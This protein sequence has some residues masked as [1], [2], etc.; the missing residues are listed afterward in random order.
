MRQQ[1]RR[2]VLGVDPKLVFVF[3]L[4]AAVDTEEFR[5]AGLRVLDG[6]DRRLVV[7]FAD[8][9][10]LAGFKDRLD[11]CA[12]GVPIGA[13]SEPYA[14]LIDAIDTL[15]P[16]AAS[17]RM[18]PEL[19]QV[20]SQRPPADELRLD[21][22]LWHPDDRALAATWA[23]ELRG[24]A[25]E[26]G[27]RV[28]DVYVNDQA[29][30]ILARVYIPADA[31]LA[32]A[33]LDT[34]AVIDV[35]PRPTL[36]VPQLYARDPVT[37][38]AMPAPRDGAPLVGL[39]DSGVAS[40][41]PLVGPA[42][43]ATESLSPAITDGEDRCG[44][45]TMVAGRILHGRVD[46][47]IA[48]GM[49]PRPFCRIVSVAVLD[50]KN[51]FPEAELWERDLVTAIEWCATNGATIINLSVG[52][53][54]RPMQSPRQL[55]AAALVDEVARRHDLVVVIAAGNVAPADYLDTN[56]IE[57]LTGYPAHL[58]AD[59]TTRILDPATSALGLTVG[60]LTEA[61]AA[62]GYLGRETAARVPLG[63]PGWPSR[64]APRAR[65]GEGGKA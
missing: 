62:G 29:G 4:G 14:G 49:I 22:E 47:A 61:L 37:L 1:S 41:H 63:E 58:L 23:A 11:A 19:V 27:G 25:T 35:L 50:A 56:D 18:S 40:A 26:G 36:T 3:E 39:I 51:N 45:G 34:I 43:A 59:K 54:R 46:Q 17:D 52:D 12:G 15:R 31:V 16:L 2:R 13:R 48:S 9:P 20:L 32:L 44:H 65:R 8:D 33:E 60:G 64:D 24:A 57:E 28:A 42:V 6:S 55:P 5:R 38:P 30:L 53:M 7:A 10:Q 21:V